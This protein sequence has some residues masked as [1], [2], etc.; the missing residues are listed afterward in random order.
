M[1]Y[2]A[3]IVQ[4][5][6]L[7]TC[8]Y[9]LWYALTVLWAGWSDRWGARLWLFRFSVFEREA[10]K[11]TLAPDQATL[12]DIAKIVE[13][14]FEVQWHDGQVM[15]ADARAN[16]RNVS[17]ETRVHTAFSAKK[18]QSALGNFCSSNQS[19]LELVPPWIRIVE[20]HQPST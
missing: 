7:K 2:P 9:Q 3:N 19:A 1:E 5:R 18:Q 16:I 15:R 8:P 14:Q 17:N 20:H 10:H 12:A 13:R 4:P 11:V 6:A